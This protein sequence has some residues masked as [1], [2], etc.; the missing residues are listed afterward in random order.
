MR[1][2]TKIIFCLERPTDNSISGLK[3][4]FQPHTLEDIYQISGEFINI[5]ELIAILQYLT[6][7]EIT[8]LQNLEKNNIL[9][10]V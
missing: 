10:S 4:K 9:R 3:T 5:V 8:C 6:T 1:D 2:I 7:V